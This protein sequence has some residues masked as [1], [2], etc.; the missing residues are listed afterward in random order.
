MCICGERFWVFVYLWGE[1]LGVFLCV[2]LAN[3]CLM[4]RCVIVVTALCSGCCYSTSFRQMT[5][6]LAKFNL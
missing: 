2:D 1:D 3:V 6:M 4:E 5:L